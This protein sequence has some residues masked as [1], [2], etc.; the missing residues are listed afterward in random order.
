MVEIVK[1]NTDRAV[2][3]VTV[4]DDFLGGSAFSKLLGPV[5]ILKLR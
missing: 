2:M 5:A 4:A 3:A 1:S